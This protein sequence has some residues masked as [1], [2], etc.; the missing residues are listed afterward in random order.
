VIDP[1]LVI[2]APPAGVFAWVLYELRRDVREPE[3]E[4]APVPVVAA[5][6]PAKPAWQ[7]SVSAP[8]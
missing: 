2:L 8:A 4:Q 6:E 7:P 5:S 1:M 3:P